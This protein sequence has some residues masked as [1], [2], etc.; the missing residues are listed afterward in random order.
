MIPDKPLTSFLARR[1]TFDSPLANHFSVVMH[2]PYKQK[3]H[4]IFPWL[5]MID[6]E[7]WEGLPCPRLILS[8]KKNTGG[9]TL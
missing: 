8:Q 3:S 5:L 6:P 4:G 2:A 7:S 1:K 9:Q